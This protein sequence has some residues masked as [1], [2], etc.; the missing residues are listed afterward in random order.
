M[1]SKSAA[2][3]PLSRPPGLLWPLGRW[4]LLRVQANR[5]VLTGR[6]TEAERLM[7]AGRTVARQTQD[8]SAQNLAGALGDLEAADAHLSRAVAMETRIGITLA[9][10][11]IAAG[12]FLTVLG[13]ANPGLL[14]HLKTWFDQQF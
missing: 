12:F 7:Q 5:A 4:H 14:D 10:I 1:C 8:A 13:R 3:P 9:F 11:A 2:S 6:F